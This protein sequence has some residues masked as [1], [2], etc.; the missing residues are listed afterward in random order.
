MRRRRSRQANLLSA[1]RRRLCIP[2]HGR[3]QRESFGRA[4]R[5]GRHGQSRLR[6]RVRKDSRLSIERQAAR[7]RVQRQPV[8]STA[9]AASPDPAPP[10][11]AAVFASTLASTLSATTV[12]SAKPSAAQP[13]APKSTSDATAE[14]TSG[15]SG[16][17]A[18]FEPACARVMRERERGRGKRE[19]KS[20]MW[21]QGKR[22][23]IGHNGRWTLSRQCVLCLQCRF[24]ATTLT[25]FS[26]CANPVPVVRDPGLPS[27]GQVPHPTPPW[28]ANLAGGT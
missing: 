11:L 10:V 24:G 7:Q 9:L 17:N 15:A 23:Q 16:A 18:E 14:S 8:A 6:R 12:A 28:L 4:D 1:A 26:V 20:E 27:A 5:D 19:E 25:T 21:L 2:L 13:T 22:L 3:R